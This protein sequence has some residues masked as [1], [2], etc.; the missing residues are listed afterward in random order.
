VFKKADRQ[1]EGFGEFCAE[2]A[3]SGVEVCEVTGDDLYA[4]VCEIFGGNLNAEVCKASCAN[5]DDALIISCTD[6][7]HCLKLDNPS[8]SDI[9]LNNKLSTADLIQNSNLPLVGLGE[10]YCGNAKYVIYDFNISVDY[11]RLIYDRLHGL[12]HVVATTDRLYLREMTVTDL[13]A[14]YELYDT[15][16]DCGYIEKLYDYEEEREFTEN[17]IKNMYC[18]FQYGLWLVFERKSGE[19]IGRVGLENREIDGATRQELGYLIRA[20]RQRCGLAYEACRACIDYAT[21]ELDITELFACIQTTNTPSA[22]LAHKLG[23]TLY[24]QNVDG[25]DVFHRQF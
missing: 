20:D 5:L 9:N 25:M 18:F 1:Y 16:A 12:P 21:R 10:D 23:F 2:L 15:L 24:A 11:I 8:I 3:K 14:M 19:L 4:Q 7:L 22:N 6:D 17:Y 13:P